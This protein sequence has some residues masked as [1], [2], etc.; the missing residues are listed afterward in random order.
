MKIIKNDFF[1]EEIYHEE[2]ENGLNVYLM[3]KKGFA[4]YYAQFTTNFGS[5]DTEFVPLGE[6]ELITVPEG[7]AHFLE[8]KMFETEDLSDVNKLFLPLGAS[9]NAFTM[10]DRTSYTVSG[11]GHV[12][13]CIEILLN[14][15]QTPTFTEQTV[16]K[17]KSIIEQE[18]LMYMD[19]PGTFATRSSYKNIFGENDKI[20]REI[21]GT[22]ESIKEITKDILLKAYHRFY[23]PANMVLAV[24][25]GFDPI[26]LMETI[27]QNQSLKSFV[28]AQKHT[29][30]LPEQMKPIK[31]R[32]K[33][34]YFDIRVPLT[35]WAVKF[36]YVDKGGLEN[37][38]IN[39]SI[40]YLFDLYYSSI[41]TFNDE[42]RKN[43]LSEVSVRYFPSYA[44]GYGYCCIRSA[45]NK[46]QQLYDFLD[47]KYEELL[48]GNID[49][50]KVRTL[51]RAGYVNNIK[52]FNSITNI[53][54]TLIECHI[55]NIDFFELTKL[56]NTISTEDIKNVLNIL[57]Q[58]IVSTHTVLPNKK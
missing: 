12:N 18:I 22:P 8:H 14:F 53:A 5:F 2:L 28:K 30:K 37:E 11:A 27:K 42:M 35:C 51:T 13:E 26:E 19:N 45:T 49:E 43:D 9:A 41:S 57:R 50:N 56:P 4:Q 40:E 48:K 10:Q 6:N 33:L 3:P 39:L 16:E 24:V 29:R 17:E 54:N 7:A 32:Y 55:R 20:A 25:G 23:H 31:E 21:G 47:K 58:G 46:Y 15:V 36:P 34:D 38:K 1:N 52:D 44:D